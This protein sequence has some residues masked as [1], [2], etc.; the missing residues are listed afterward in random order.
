MSARQHSAE[1]CS[2]CIVIYL[3]RH[4]I[5]NVQGTWTCNV[6]QITM[7]GPSELLPA[8]QKIGCAVVVYFGLYIGLC[9]GVWLKTVFAVDIAV[10][11]V[12]IEDLEDQQSSFGIIDFL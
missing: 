7:S 4:V 8:Y 6:L 5:K 9:W 1:I 2:V 11:G 10:V 12:I 3:C